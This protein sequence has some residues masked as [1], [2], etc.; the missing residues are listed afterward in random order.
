MILPIFLTTQY[1]STKIDEKS[2]TLAKQS[3]INLRPHFDSLSPIVSTSRLRELLKGLLT[4]AQLTDFKPVV[5]SIIDNNFDIEL[6]YDFKN[7]LD[8]VPFAVIVPEYYYPKAVDMLMPSDANIFLN[9]AMYGLKVPEDTKIQLDSIAVG[10]YVK[11]NVGKFISQNQIVISTADVETDFKSEYTEAMI[12]ALADNIQVAGVWKVVIDSR[13]TLFPNLID[14]LENHTEIGDFFEAFDDDADGKLIIAPGVK[15]LELGENDSFE[16][17]PLTDQQ[18]NKF[19][20]KE[21]DKITFKWKSD[22]SKFEGE[23]Y[24]SKTGIRIDT[25]ARS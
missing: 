20:I 22:K 19:K 23:I 4:E 11:E 16:N 9:C 18:L 1:V 6:G 21:E 8:S 14:A 2:T 12:K 3:L 5:L 25:R 13:Y 24:G 10:L 15:E 17:L 7:I